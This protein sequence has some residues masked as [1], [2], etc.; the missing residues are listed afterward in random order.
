MRRY[1]TSPAA[2]QTSCMII[3]CVSTLPAWITEQPQD[4]VLLRRQLHLLAA[5]PYHAVHQIDAKIATL[6]HRLTALVLDAVT[7]G[8]ADARDQVRPSRTAS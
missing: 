5:D 6:E 7:Q 1:W 4:V 8:G 3:R 2:P